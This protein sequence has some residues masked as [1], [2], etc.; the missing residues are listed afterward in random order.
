MTPPYS[1]FWYLVGLLALALGV[2]LFAMAIASARVGLTL[3][4]WR[5]FWRCSCF[6]VGAGA[7][8]AR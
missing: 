3:F 5:R 4:S 8:C 1:R 2:V 7:G 6:L